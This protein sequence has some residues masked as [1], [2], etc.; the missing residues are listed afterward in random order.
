[1]VGRGDGGGI[2]DSPRFGVT[3]RRWDECMFVGRGAGRVDMEEVDVGPSR[4]I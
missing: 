4:R 3:E 2:K 1:M